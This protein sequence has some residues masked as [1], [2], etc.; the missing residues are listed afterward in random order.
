MC[1]CSLVF[2][3]LGWM[4]SGGVVVMGVLAVLTCFVC[5]QIR[6][7]LFPGATGG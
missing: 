7:F 6:R 3:R 5:P 4:G 1:V 2:G